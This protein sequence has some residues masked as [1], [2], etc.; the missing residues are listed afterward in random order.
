MN[1]LG[2]EPYKQLIHTN[3]A[4]LSSVATIPVI[5]IPDEALELRIETRNSDNNSCFK[6]LKEIFLDNEWCCN[7]EQTETASKILFITTKDDLDTG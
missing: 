2:P 5:G 7:I 1:T 6:T 4:Y 3:N